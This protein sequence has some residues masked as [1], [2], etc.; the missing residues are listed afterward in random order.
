[1]RYLLELG[2]G[3]HWG[4]RADFPLCVIF[5]ELLEEQPLPILSRQAEWSILPKYSCSSSLKREGPRKT[6]DFSLCGL[7]VCLFVF[8]FSPPVPSGFIPLFL[9]RLYIQLLSW[10]ISVQKCCERSVTLAAVP[11]PTSVPALDLFAALGQRHGLDLYSAWHF[12]EQKPL[13]GSK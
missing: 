8:I 12:G 4:R 7:F 11:V 6:G 2:G 10:F 1:M 3:L 9:H 13:R 5:H